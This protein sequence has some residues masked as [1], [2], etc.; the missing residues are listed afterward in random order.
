[1]DGTALATEAARYLEV[2][3]L[4]R[5]LELNVKWRSEADEVG[6]TLVGLSWLGLFLDNGPA[7]EIRAAKRHQF[8]GPGGPDD[9]FANDPFD[10]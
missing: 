5:S 4:F 1:M 9:P 3:D 6:V 2:I 10:G 8:L 7:D